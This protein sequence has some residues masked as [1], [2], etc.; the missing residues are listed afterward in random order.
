MHFFNDYN[1]ATV[2]MVFNCDMHYQIKAGHFIPP[3]DYLDIAGNFNNQGTYDVLFDSLPGY[4]E[5]S[6]YTIKMLIDTSY[7]NG[8]PLSFKFR[9]NGNWS[10]AEFPNGG[11]ARQYDLLDTAGGVFNVYSCWYDD[12]NPNVP[13]PPWAYNLA[14]QGVLV[15]GNVLS[16]SYTYEDV[17]GDP[18]GISHYWWYW[19]DDTLGTNLTAIIGA[20]SIT[21][22]PTS[23]VTGKYLA[24]EVTPIALTGDSLTGKPVRVYS[25]TPIGGLGIDDIHT[26]TVRYYPNPVSDNLY[27][28]NLGETQRIEIF[29]IVGQPV[30]ALDTPHTGRAVFN[31][32]ALRPGIYFLRFI[33]RDH[34]FSTGRFIRN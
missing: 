21:Y 16:G 12:K 17:N 6:I 25:A 5:D 23:D 10:T 14:I 28:E 15:Y 9:F 19:A 34:S 11:P 13:S 30:G 26:T 27:F 32:S 4:P 7:I 3:F 20:D 1:P 33:A 24:F 22:V 8:A 2:P 18:E 29:S 31:V